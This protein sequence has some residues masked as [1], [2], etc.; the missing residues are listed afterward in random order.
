MPVNIVNP[1]SYKTPSLDLVDH[2]AYFKYER[3]WLLLA[4]P[5][6]SIVGFYCFFGS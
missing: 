6:A 1:Y 5:Y 2:N 3:T 4:G